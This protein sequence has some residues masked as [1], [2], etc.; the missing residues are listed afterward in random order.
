MPVR[1]IHPETRLHTT[2]KPYLRLLTA[3]PSMLKSTWRCLDSPAGIEI[4]CILISVTVSY[5]HLVVFV[6][7]MCYELGA[8]WRFIGAGNR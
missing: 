8:R 1:Q 6:A 4:P 7:E 3:G 5:H 2:V